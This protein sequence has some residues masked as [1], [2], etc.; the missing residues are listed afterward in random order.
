MGLNLQ[1]V[2]LLLPRLREVPGNCRIC[3]LLKS[4]QTFYLYADRWI[5]TWW[6]SDSLAT[7]TY[8]I[9]SV[10]RS[11][12][13]KQIIQKRFNCF[14]TNGNIRQSLRSENGNFWKPSS[15]HWLPRSIFANCVVLTI[16]FVTKRMVLN[17]S[18][19]Y[20]NQILT[21]DLS[22]DQILIMML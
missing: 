9:N 20:L 6:S 5:D 18:N 19:Y 7:C 17:V 11:G 16:I 21:F 14:E 3:S 2:E 15:I 13:S 22:K 8:I 10:G 12:M 4:D 1:L